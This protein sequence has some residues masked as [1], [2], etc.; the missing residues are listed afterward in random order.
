MGKQKRSPT[1][2]ILK[3]DATEINFTSKLTPHRYMGY[4]KR[5]NEG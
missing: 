2:S 1:R 5:K 3:K 4:S